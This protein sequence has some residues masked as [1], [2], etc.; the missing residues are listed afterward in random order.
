ML[1][2][3]EEACGIGTINQAVVVAQREVD[4]AAHGDE[5]V[6]VVVG[7]HHRALHDCA[8]AQNRNLWKVDDRRVEERTTAAG[9]GDGE[10]AAA[11]LIGG[12]FVGA[13]ALCDISDAPG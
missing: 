9:V 7:H 10:R 4:H 6:A 11:Q 8:G 3:P 12:D 1:D 2:R 5:I 13:S